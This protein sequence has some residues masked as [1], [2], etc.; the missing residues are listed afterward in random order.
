M[1]SV[2]IATPPDD[3]SGSDTM[4]PMNS[5]TLTVEPSTVT[6]MLAAT[7]DPPSATPARAA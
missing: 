6:D 1:P 7:P 3:M 4:P 2:T 5:T